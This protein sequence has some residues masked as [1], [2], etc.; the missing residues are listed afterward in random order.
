MT[1]RFAI[2]RVAPS[3]MLSAG[4]FPSAVVSDGYVA[5]A[6]AQTPPDQP[7]RL[8]QTSLMAKDGWCSLGVLRMMGE[9]L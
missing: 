3:T 8:R 9:S 5:D 4:C 2:G 7:T 6:A 1:A